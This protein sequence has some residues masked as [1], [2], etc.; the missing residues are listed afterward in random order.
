MLYISHKVY[1]NPLLNI[2]SY[3]S[4]NSEIKGLNEGS[5]ANRLRTCLAQLIVYDGINYYEQLP[6]E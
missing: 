3:K 4:R 2:P 1:Y 5:I 6:F